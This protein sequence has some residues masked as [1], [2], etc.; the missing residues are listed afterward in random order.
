MNKQAEETFYVAR[1]ALRDGVQEAVGRCASVENWV[2]LD[3]YVIGMKLGR[4]VFRNRAEAVR[5][6]ETMRE[7]K[8]ASLH[9][10][11]KKLTALEFK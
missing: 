8:I 5:R 7:K 10:Q 9:K 3:G 11:V 1:Y 2:L 4:D 6:A